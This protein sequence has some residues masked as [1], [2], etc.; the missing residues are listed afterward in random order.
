MV[1]SV[2]DLEPGAPPVQVAVFAYLF[3]SGGY[4]HVISVG[5]V[6]SIFSLCLSLS[7]S[8]SLPLPLSISF[9]LSLSPSLSF[10][11]SLSLRVQ[12]SLQEKASH[13]T[14][15]STLQWKD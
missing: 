15:V 8:P 1:C 7:L 4:L 9:S 10:S 14:L 11:L 3:V 13:S 6:I 12:L 2:R 5:R